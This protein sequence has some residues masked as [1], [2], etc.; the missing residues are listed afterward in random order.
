M[1]AARTAVL[2]SAV[3]LAAF[4]QGDGDYG[5]G[6]D[7]LVPDVSD[8]HFAM[9]FVSQTVQM[10]SYPYLL[11]GGSVH[12]TENFMYLYPPVPLLITNNYPIPTA[13]HAIWRR[14]GLVSPPLF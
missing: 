13:R 7:P 9:K 4:A 5:T 11:G 14:M 1:R 6:D 12:K 8:D 3:V 10:G 2:S